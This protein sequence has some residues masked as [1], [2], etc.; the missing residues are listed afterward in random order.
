MLLA[1]ATAFLLVPL[2]ITEDEDLMEINMKEAKVELEKK[3]D[4]EKEITLLLP[5]NMSKAEVDSFKAR[6]ANVCQL[7]DCTGSVIPVVSD[8]VELIDSVESLP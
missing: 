6:A 2:A 5:E 8:Q 7:P 1:K 4:S 3:V